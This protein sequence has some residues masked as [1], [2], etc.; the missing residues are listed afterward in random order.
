MKLT[1]T[2]IR[3]DSTIYESL[4]LFLF[5]DYYAILLN[6]VHILRYL[7]TCDITKFCI[8]LVIS[9]S[10]KVQC[11]TNLSM[12]AKIYE[13][14][15]YVNREE[16]REI[17][18]NSV[19]FKLIETMP[20]KKNNIEY[21]EQLADL[22]DIDKQAFLVKG[23]H[24][25]LCPEEISNLTGLSCKGKVF[26]EKRSASLPTYFVN[27]CS[28]YGKTSNEGPVS[29]RLIFE[30]LKEMVIETGDDRVDFERLLNTMLTFFITVKT[31]EK[32]PR[33]C[34]VFCESLEAFKD[35]NWPATICDNTICFL[36]ERHEAKQKDKPNKQV[37]CMI[38]IVEAWFNM[39]TRL[40]SAIDT[41]CTVDGDELAPM[42]HYLS[43]HLLK[44]DA[45][46][47]FE[48]LNPD[49]VLN[50]RDPRCS[51]QERLLDDENVQTFSY[52]CSTYVLIAV[53]DD[54]IGIV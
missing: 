43:R 14:E 50:C 26:A 36:K 42:L 10:N 5:D 32:V 13:A 23:R 16:K 54:F 6:F 17:C 12:V 35:I 4:L 18:K 46:R 2:I 33:G 45:A 9:D 34:M 7:D 1:T 41:Q 8:F 49:Q 21:F 52:H 24:L 53:T 47:L 3:H 44:S 39:R 19:F 15:G 29:V 30:L 20:K 31:Q 37:R 51:S 25:K 11:R 22:Y 48:Q 27:L 38:Q 40:I 28:K